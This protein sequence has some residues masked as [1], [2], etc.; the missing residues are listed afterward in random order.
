MAEKPNENAGHRA[1]AHL[2]FAIVGPLL[3]APPENLGDAITELAARTWQ[4]PS[5]P[6]RPL[7]FAFST[8]ERWY[9]EAKRAADPVGNLTR[10][11]R[12]DAGQEKAL[13]LGFV[14][15][16]DGPEQGALDVGTPLFP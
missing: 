14:H 13:T 6:E 4:H 12:K 9:Y 10:R 3:A 5:R 11:I 15:Q 7:K 1:W 16:Q 8:I 2:R